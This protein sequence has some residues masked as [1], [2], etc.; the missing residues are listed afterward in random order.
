ML[1]RKKRQIVCVSPSHATF[2][3]TLIDSLSLSIQRGASR[4]KPKLS[5]APIY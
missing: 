4:L 5:F 3:P 2:I 1:P